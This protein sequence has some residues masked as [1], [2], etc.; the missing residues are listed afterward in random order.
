VSENQLE[1]H[2]RSTNG[3]SMPMEDSISFELFKQLKQK[4]IKRDEMAQAR[5]LMSADA[6]VINMLAKAS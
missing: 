6:K 2:S 3:C 5:G 4:Y 1:L